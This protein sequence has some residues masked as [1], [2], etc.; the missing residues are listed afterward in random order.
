MRRV[1]G[2]LSPMASVAA[3]V[4]NRVTLKTVKTLSATMSR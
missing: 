2:V 4:T 3:S 1:A